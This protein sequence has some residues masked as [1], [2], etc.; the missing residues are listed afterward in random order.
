MDE[1]LVASALTTVKDLISPQDTQDFSTESQLQQRQRDEAASRKSLDTLLEESNQVQRARLATTESRFG[2]WLDALPLKLGLLPDE[3]VRVGVALGL[4][5][6]VCLPHRC[7]CGAMADSLG[8]HQLFC[9]RETRRLSRHAAINIIRSRLAAAEVLALLEPLDLDHSDGPRPDNI[10]ITPFS[11]GRSL[12]W[13]AACSNAF[14][15]TQVPD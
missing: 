5:I 3:A 4:S 15:S 10:T 13:D 12:V 14:N 1:Y 7:K 8:H 9:P 2:A 6:L 11:S